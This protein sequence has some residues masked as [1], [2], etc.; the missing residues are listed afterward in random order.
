MEFDNQSE[1][2]PTVRQAFA[3]FF[4]LGVNGQEV[5]L[6]LIEEAMITR[7]RDFPEGPSSSQATAE[8][9]DRRWE[10]YLQKLGDRFAEGMDPTHWG[11]H[12]GNLTDL[13]RQRNVFLKI[14]NNLDG[15]RLLQAKEA[16][17]MVVTRKSG[18]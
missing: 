6:P 4:E 17:E 2:P 15:A 11:G 14:F 13:E 7:G 5:A 16:I 10:D 12:G 9:R 18:T 8:A 3:T 1:L